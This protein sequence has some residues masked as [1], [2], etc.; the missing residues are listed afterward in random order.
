MAYV[1][2]VELAARQY[3]RFSRQQLADLGVGD[4]AIR[5]RLASGDWTAVNDG[6]YGIAPVFDDDRGR[7][8]AATLTARGSVLSHASS[9]AAWGWWDRDRSFEIVTRPG[10]GGPR[11]QDGV[12]IHFSE[13]LAGDTTTRFG[14]PITR[15]PRTLLD[16]VPHVS[17]PLL[18]RCVRESIRLRTTT[19]VEIMDALTR[20]HRGRRG[21]RRLALTVARYEGLPIHRARSGVEVEAL[22][23]LR[24]AGR[25]MPKFNHKVAGREADLVWPKER[26]IIEID[27]DEYH[28]DRGEDLAKEELWAAAGFAVRRLPAENVA[29][30]LLTIAPNVRD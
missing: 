20:P 15:V 11:R 13:R 23:L 19:T 26:L 6:V 16:L 1:R 27:G 14:I 28:L 29:A 3:N 9:G 7:W 24:A 10:N 12:L 8:M 17:R 18:A 22:L 4:E 21:S 30:D 25:P 5:H 2:V